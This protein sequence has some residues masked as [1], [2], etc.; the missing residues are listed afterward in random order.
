MA[1]MPPSRVKSS[2]MTLV[3]R[4]E[5]RR[6]PSRRPRLERA[7]TTLRKEEDPRGLLFSLPTLWLRQRRQSARRASSPRPT[8]RCGNVSLRLGAGVQASSRRRFCSSQ[9]AAS[10]GPSAVRG[11]T[12]AP[13][14]RRFARSGR[15]RRSSGRTSRRGHEPAQMFALSSLHRISAR[16]AN[17]TATGAHRHVGRHRE[18]RAGWRPSW[19]AGH[20]RATARL[21]SADPPTRGPTKKGQALRF[22]ALPPV[23][24]S[25]EIRM[26]GFASYRDDQVAVRAGRQSNVSSY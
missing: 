6:R 8:R 4:W 20:P 26:D 14:C 10:I 5:W 1:G 7:S 16:T 25:L 12:V 21:S 19:R 9:C 13:L 24:Y 22:Q 2:A 17:R 11:K 15:S 23:L 3:G 18:R